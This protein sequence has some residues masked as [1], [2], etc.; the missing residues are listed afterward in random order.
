M[1]VRL[2]NWRPSRWHRAENFGELL[3]F[4]GNTSLFSLSVFLSNNLA[5]ILI[6]KFVGTSELGQYN[7][8]Q[9]LINLPMSNIVQPITQATMPLLTHLRKEPSEYR[10]AY[11]NL[12]RNLS[13]AL[14]PLSVILAFAGS[15][16]V[17]ILIGAQ[18]EQAGYIVSALAPILA[19]MGFS[20]GVADLFITQDRAA[21]LRTLGLFEVLIRA[22][23][24]GLGLS[25]GLVGAAIGFSLST[26]IVAV[27]RV[28]V[29]GRSGPVTAIDQLRQVLPSMPL[30]A[31]ALFGCLLIRTADLELSFTVQGLL[32]IAAS[33]ASALGVGIL[34]PHSRRALIEL[35][36][37]F[38]VKRLRNRDR[39][40]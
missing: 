3:R 40:S 32:L 36:S 20:Y 9:A 21:E 2:S 16:L 8:A 23:S 6:G 5:S 38:G 26:I 27:V 25:F 30:A 11:L 1:F 14:V 18:W 22:G 39:K 24:I 37:L 34:V 13:T 35:I 19:I 28:L 15:S 31:G 4:G 33:G 17:H 7:R 29:V 12:V 10:I